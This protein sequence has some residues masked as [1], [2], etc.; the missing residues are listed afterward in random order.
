MYTQNH[1]GLPPLPSGLLYGILHPLLVVPDHWKKSK[2]RILNNCNSLVFLGT[3]AS[4]TDN[5]CL[6][7]DLALMHQSIESLGGG[8]VGGGG[9]GTCGDTAQEKINK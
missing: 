6:V 3:P 9:G 4:S 1:P 8:G 7:A 5:D 2:V